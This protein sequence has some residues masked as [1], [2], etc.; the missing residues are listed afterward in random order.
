[1]EA[2]AQEAKGGGG[3]E[4]MERLASAIFKEA[5]GQMADRQYWEA[6]KN[7]ILITDYYSSFSKLDEVLYT[8]GECLYQLELL[9]AS[10]RIWRYL[11]KS[12]LHSPYVPW[13][14][15]GIERVYYKRGDYERVLDYFRIIRKRYP[16]AAI[17][18]GAYY[19][20]GQA[21]FNR[22]LYDN[23]ILFFEAISK[24]SEFWGYAQYSKALAYLKKKELNGAFRL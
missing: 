17:A 1:M 4:E 24:N 14:L 5:Q 8:L 15:Y 23:A 9:D 11:I 6:A 13:A 20:A 22:E 12:Y 2:R 10:E 19:Y 21:L 3:V 18:D 7:L 16:K